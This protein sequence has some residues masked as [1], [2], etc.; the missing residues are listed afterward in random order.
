MKKK[1]VAFAV[2]AAMVVTSAVPALAWEASVSGDDLTAGNQIVVNKNLKDGIV[3]EGVAGEIT[4]GKAFTTTV[5]LNRRVGQ[6]EYVLE[7]STDTKEPAKIKLYLGN[8]ADGKTEMGL[9]TKEDDYEK[10]ADFQGLVDITWSFTVNEKG[11]WLDIFVQERGK[12]ASEGGYNFEYQI[13]GTLNTVDYLALNAWDDQK[14]VD[15]ATITGEDQIVIYQDAATAPKEV[16]SVEV[17]KA[18]RDTDRVYKP[19]IQYGK[20]V[21]VT[22]PVEGETYYVNSIT[23]DDGTVIEGADVEKYVSFEWQAVKANGTPVYT[24]NAANEQNATTRHFTVEADK[25]DGCFISLVATAKKAAGV[26]GDAT[27]GADAEALAVQQ[28]LA[29]EDRYETA[30]KVA[31]Q[32]KT[33]EGFANY[34]VATGTNYADALSATALAN[35]M[36]API[37][38]VNGNNGD[39][40]EEVAAYIE[41]NAASYKTTTVYVVGGTSAVSA[42]FEKLLYKFDVDVVRLAGDT[43]YDTNIKVLEKYDE[44]VAP[45]KKDVVDKSDMAEILVASG[46]NYPD[47]LSASAARKP[48]LLVG[49]ELTSA[50]KDYLQTLAPVSAK[51]K[52]TYYVNNYV[53]VGGTSAV[54]ADV[55]AELSRPAYVKS[56]SNVSRLWGDDRYETN[57]AVIN[58]YITKANAKYVFVAYGMD[59]ADAL[60]GGVLAAKYGCPLVLVDNNNTGIAGHIVDTVETAADNT[61]GGLV[62]IGG[63]AVISNELVQKIA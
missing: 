49:D 13:P 38:L 16:A 51:N 52:V 3:E 11:T 9:V 20:P 26:F 53:I 18:F 25:Y 56:A 8:G 1:L 39:Y 61:Y 57:M 5:D 32:M 62:V 2:T 4:H 50:Q 47:A 19:V 43:R 60:T 36:G 44:V 10:G 34:F 41:K 22:Q 12:T 46:K 14:M 28:R 31:D 37:L 17:V 24:K 6:F 23:L 27:W 40:E 45:D 63:E 15:D 54:N 7:L 59:Y 29:G 55:K 58:A 35:E 21:V 48:V 30:I 33:S 42:E